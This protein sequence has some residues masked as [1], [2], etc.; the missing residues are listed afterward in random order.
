MKV[1]VSFLKLSLLFFLGLACSDDPVSSENNSQLKGT[2][3]ATTFIEPG[4]A[5]G[6]IDIL[7]NGGELTM[8]FRDN[9][10]VEGRLMIPDNIGSNFSPVDTNY[11]GSYSLNED[12]IRFSNTTDLLDSPTIYFL[13]R[14]SSLETPD[15]EGRLS[16]LKIIL[17]KQ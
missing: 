3:G 15:Y 12:T 17:E 9:Y 5:D 11:S 7:E 2:Y 16:L 8:E 6:G 4:S 10:F 14:D 1:I 13:L